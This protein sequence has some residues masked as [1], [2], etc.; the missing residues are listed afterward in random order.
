MPFKVKTLDEMNFSDKDKDSFIYSSMGT[1][2]ARFSIGNLHV[3]GSQCHNKLGVYLS[4]NHNSY[5]VVNDLEPCL[6]SIRPKLKEFL[7]ANHFADDSP[8]SD[9]FE[10]MELFEYDDKLFYYFYYEGKSPYIRRMLL[11]FSIALRALSEGDSVY[12]CDRETHNYG[13]KHYLYL[14]DTFGVNWREAAV[15]SRVIKPDGTPKTFDYGRPLWK[16]HSDHIMNHHFLPGV[17]SKAFVSGRPLI[18]DKTC[19]TFSSKGNDKLIWGVDY[20]FDKAENFPENKNRRITFGTY[21]PIPGNPDWT[22]ENIIKA[23]KGQI[24]NHERKAA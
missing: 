6:N 9:L 5:L 19:S 20:F 8:W 23:V 13:L 22:T 11:N 12:K 15:L 14:M 7:L 16:P 21:Y 4:Y 17:F 24:D 2:R 18:N 1:N 10:H 3:E